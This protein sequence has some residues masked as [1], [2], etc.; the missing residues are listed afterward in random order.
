MTK[1]VTLINV[2]TNETVQIHYDSL[3]TSAAIHEER[4]K[5]ISKFYDM[6]YRHLR[7][8]E[9]QVKS[10]ND[11]NGDPIDKDTFKSVTRVFVYTNDSAKNGAGLN[12]EL[13]EDIIP[14]INI[15]TKGGDEYDFISALAEL[16]DNS[17]QNTVNE[18]ERII[19]INFNRKESTLQIT[20]TGKGMK[21]DEVKNW[22]T[23]GVSDSPDMTSH[24]RRNSSHSMKQRKYITSDFSRY[25]VG[26]K[27]A[28]FNIGSM[29][30]LCSKSASSPHVSQ[31]SLD[32]RELNV[33]QSWKARIVIRDPSKEER[34]HDS[35]T[36]IIISDVNDL[37]TSDYQPEEVRKKLS[38]LYHYYVFGAQGNRMTSSQTQNADDSDDDTPDGDT[39]PEVQ[40]HVDGKSLAEVDDDLE[41]QYLSKGRR[42][43]TF[44]IPL[45]VENIDNKRP[46]DNSQGSKTYINSK[47]YG[48]IYYFP[49]EDGV[50]TLPTP[51]LKDHEISGGEMSLHDRNP[52]FEVFWNGR[53]LPRAHIRSLKFMQDIKRGRDL[54]ATCLSRIKGMLFV[55]SSFV[56]SATKLDLKREGFPLYTALMQYDDRKVRKTFASWLVKCHK[57][58]DMEIKFLEHDH[59]KNSTDGRFYYYKLVEFRGEKIRV[60]DHVKMAGRPTV[61]GTITGIYREAGSDFSYTCFLNV[62]EVEKQVEET[63]PITMLKEKL[64]EKQFNHV[65]DKIKQKSIHKL[66]VVKTPKVPVHQ[67]QLPASADAGFQLDYI[68]VAIHDGND[69]QVS[70]KNAQISMVV[71]RKRQN[72]TEK[73]IHRRV[74]TQPYKGALY[75]FKLNSKKETF[76]N[77]EKAGTYTFEFS[78]DLQDVKPIKVKIN[79]RPLSP[80][81]LMV[82]PRKPITVR[83]GEHFETNLVLVDQYKNSVAFKDFDPDKLELSL[84][85]E[86][87]HESIVLDTDHIEVESDTC[88]LVKNFQ[89][90]KG[91]TAE[92]NPATFVIECTYDSFE[93]ALLSGKLMPGAPH[94]LVLSEDTQ[95]LCARGTESPIPR[96]SLYIVDS[97]DNKLTVANSECILSSDT[98]DR[99]YEAAPNERT[100]EYLFE[101]LM[102]IGSPPQAEINVSVS[103]ED[104]VVQEVQFSIPIHETVSPPHSGHLI[105][106][107]ANV[108]VV[109]RENKKISIRGP[110][111][112][113]LSDITFRIVDSND[114]YMDDLSGICTLCDFTDTEDG[115]EIIEFTEGVI[116]LKDIEFPDDEE[117]TLWR[118]D[119]AP[120]KGRKWF[121]YEFHISS[122]RKP[123]VGFSLEECPSEAACSEP[124]SI[125]FTV[126]DEMG[127][128]FVK[129]SDDYKRYESILTKVAPAID[130]THP[131][132]QDIEWERLELEQGWKVDCDEEGV[133]TISNIKVKGFPAKYPFKL[134]LRDAG[135]QFSTS[136]DATVNLIPGPVV[137]SRLDKQTR[138]FREVCNYG[139]IAGMEL[140]GHDMCG[141]LSPFSAESQVVMD[142]TPM[143][144]IEF[145]C[146]EDN[147]NSISLTQKDDG[148]MFIPPIFVKAKVGQTY[149]LDLYTTER[150]GDIHSFVE[151]KIL[152]SN[153]PAKIVVVTGVEDSKTKSLTAGTTLGPFSVRL[154]GEDGQPALGHYSVDMRASFKNK[155]NPETFVGQLNEDYPGVYDFKQSSFNLI[156]AGPLE[157]RFR[158]DFSGCSNPLLRETESLIEELRFN[159]L[160]SAPDTLR[161]V[162]GITST[163][164]SNDPDEDLQ[165]RTLFEQVAIQVVDEMGNCC[166]SVDGGVV[167]LSTYCENFDEVPRLSGNLTAQMVRGEA[168]YDSSVS[169]V[170]NS[171][172]AGRHYS[173]VASYDYEGTQLEASSDFA[174]ADMRKQKLQIEKIS[175]DIAKCH[176]MKREINAEITKLSELKKDA[177][178]K[179]KLVEDKRKYHAKEM[180]QKYGRAISE[181]QDVLTL[182]DMQKEYK[183]KLAAVED[184]SVRRGDRGK[185]SEE[186][187]YI[188]KMK[189]EN[190]TQKTGI[191]GL[192]IDL[193]FV[194][195]ERIDCVL[196]S[197]LRGNLHVVVVEN[198]VASE[199]LSRKVKAFGMR[200]AVH[201]VSLDRL[202]SQ[203]RTTLRNGKIGFKDEEEK[204]MKQFEGY[205]GP[206]VNCV[207]ISENQNQNLRHIFH[208]YMGNTRIFDTEANARKAQKILFEKNLKVD[209]LTLDH[210]F[211]RSNGLVILEPNKKSSGSESRR[212]GSPPFNRKKEEFQQVI[213]DFDELI[214]LTTESLRIYEEDVVT[215]QKDCE[216]QIKKLKQ[217]L[218]KVMEDIDR[219][220]KMKLNVCDENI[221]V[222]SQQVNAPLKRSSTRKKKRKAKKDTSTVPR[223]KR[224]SQREPS[225]D[226]DEA[227][228]EF[229]EDDDIRTD[230]DEE[231]QPQNTK[232]RKRRRLNE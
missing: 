117:V 175:N 112:H 113:I 140:S 135:N 104:E 158:V 32:K 212:F 2:N 128:S 221:E 116:R 189:D 11:A 216:P 196:C 46:N 81:R 40:I 107:D 230:E 199:R 69:K 89:I 18:R 13:E 63:H 207:E 77:F 188:M 170:P 70:I 123:P 171:A 21:T 74:A 166:T 152:P 219:M 90:T 15:L 76:V 108:Q 16:V 54:P 186:I 58:L 50:E 60:G 4:P 36:T 47:V 26:S 53:L 200:R 102:I 27:R 124:F 144:D 220:T 206:A 87:S 165:G 9:N 181:C 41:S 132:T 59:E 232:R 37:Y 85:G 187:E 214:R 28:I 150:S 127:G 38:H 198:D 227:I 119:F 148:A 65:L 204:F 114:Q 183:K 195:D 56:V 125:K 83:I 64:N 23:M 173:L 180:E 31:V 75:C 194:E 49:T 139:K 172:P 103:V 137:E 208:Y 149:T 35:F 5:S 73:D 193:G 62:E 164:I 111:E 55:D 68:T 146:A 205:I 168:C 100:M 45:Q 202:V 57:D 211:L 67:Q 17:I 6:V 178:N 92:D 217:Q 159:V 218:R 142:F 126:V 10:C 160:H 184:H 147:S 210:S 44:S 120:A 162:P 179:H 225:P 201:I 190:P 153:V 19:H 91:V 3:G 118:L 29:V 143:G 192:V 7:V 51:F 213:R 42:K 1:S 167:S 156:H 110:R 182:K 115:N 203:A 93:P 105:I 14:H 20:D 154:E 88:V 61:Y 209:L 229:N 66:K 84:N 82:T 43:L 151:V 197:Q 106:E 122:F 191:L 185:I 130:V 101:E 96:I 131:L 215:T 80:H 22:A 161:F 8:S 121:T 72:G 86:S 71:K 177:V 136:I 25:G 133:Y 78:T 224:R 39:S 145:R 231:P 169:V 109:T 134:G 94:K 138:L 97:S 79:I 163:T 98:L 34:R 99:D 24:F 95:R 129:D 228:F 157:I 33:N 141:N 226:L 174:Y 12:V 48:E 155:A 52:G 30:T 223:K 222:T 176:E